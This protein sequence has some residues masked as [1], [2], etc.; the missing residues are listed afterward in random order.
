VDDAEAS[1]S[2]EGTIG[3][4]ARPCE[5]SGKRCRLRRG[6]TWE[7]VRAE[8]ASDQVTIV[9]DTGEWVRE[10]DDNTASQTE[11]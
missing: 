11:V 4:Y 9:T 1:L 3:A 7:V 2:D 8:V 10:E 6:H 5:T